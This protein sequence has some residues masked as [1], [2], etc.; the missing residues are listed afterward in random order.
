MTARSYVLWFTGLSGAGKSTL[1]NE[2]H[3]MYQ[4]RGLNSY[5]LDGDR[6]RSSLN[7]DL[8]YTP[9]DRAENIRRAGEVAKILTEAG[10]IVMAAFISPYKRDREMIR[11]MFA[12]GTFIEVYVQCPLQI[13]E[14]RDPKGLYK[15]AR[16]GTISDFTGISSEYEAPEHPEVVVTADHMS[17]PASVDHIVAYLKQRRLLS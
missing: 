15:L 10:V 8:G 5:V 1:A 17:I 13:C 4:A 7:R 3:A 2:M 6:L 11:Q 14:A 12:A 9:N 16:A